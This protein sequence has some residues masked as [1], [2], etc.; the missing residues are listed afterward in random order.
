MDTF[1]SQPSPLPEQDQ[2]IHALKSEREQA[3]ARFF[4]S[5]RPRL[6]RIAGFRLDHR[7][8]GRVSDSDVLQ[9]TFVRAAQRL[10]HFLTQPAL[11]FFVWL[12]MELNQKLHE[13]HR[14]HLTTAKRDARMEVGLPHNQGGG[15]TSLAIAAQLVASLTSP[16]RAVQKAEQIAFVQQSLNQLPELDRE[17]IALRHFEELSNAEVAQVLGIDSSAASKR[18]LRALKRLQEI[19]SQLRG[20]DGP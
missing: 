17:V 18:Y 3:L 7:L 2:I 11:P 12:R 10:D 14:H 9:E 20:D 1:D 15:D 13:I 6:K 4:Q 8:G 19:I 16:S 5:A